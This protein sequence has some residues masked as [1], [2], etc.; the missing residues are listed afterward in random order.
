MCWGRK[1][2]TCHSVAVRGWPFF[3]I[4]RLCKCH[5]AAAIRQNPNGVH[6][7]STPRHVSHPPA[8]IH[9]SKTDNKVQPAPAFLSHFFFNNLPFSEWWRW[10]KWS[11]LD[12]PLAFTNADELCVSALLPL[13]I[14]FGCELF[15]LVPTARVTI[16]HFDL[17]WGE[18]GRKFPT[19]CI[20]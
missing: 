20:L 15:L 10:W 2:F 11:P 16:A 6:R 8:I 18:I 19:F 3:S 4:S 17:H 5:C 7:K 14:L 12:E 13:C 1:I 9:Q